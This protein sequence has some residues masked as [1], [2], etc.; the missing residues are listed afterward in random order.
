MSLSIVYLGKRGGGAELSLKLLEDLIFKDHAVVKS[1]IIAPSNQRKSAFQPLRTQ[2]IEFGGISNVERFKAVIKTIF[3]PTKTLQTLGL[4]NGDIVIFP[5]VSPLDLAINYICRQ[6]GM[7]VVRFLHDSNKHPGDIWPGKVTINWIIKNSDVIVAMSKYVKSKISHQYR[8]KVIVVPHP[9][10]DFWKQDS[11]TNFRLPSSYI[12]FIGRLREYKGLNLLVAA[13]EK[14]NIEFKIDLVIA[15]EGDAKN[16]PKDG[17]VFIN[18]WL[19]ESEIFELVSGAEIVA[20]PYTEA[21]QSGLIPFVMSS[22]KKIVTTPM[23]GLIEQLT[24]YAFTH[25]SKSTSEEDFANA[26]KL[27]LTNNFQ[28]NPEKIITSDFWLENLLEKLNELKTT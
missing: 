12:L 21:S 8:S 3:S 15:G 7:K 24:N 20:F 2:L 4:E 19:S 27:S 10:F 18:R 11:G 14:I 23:P 25:I 16:L 6:K 26:L 1:M 28:R 13:W 22:G 5:M 9:A 17:I